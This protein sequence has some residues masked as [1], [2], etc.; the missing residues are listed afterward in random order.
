MSEYIL[1]I[2]ATLLAVDTL[3]SIYN[4][5]YSYFLELKHRYT[6]MAKIPLPYKNKL[7]MQLDEEVGGLRRFVQSTY[8]PW[9]VFCFFTAMVFATNIKCVNCCT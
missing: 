4:F 6:T 3:F 1:V 2:S 7:T 9:I 8:L 5:R